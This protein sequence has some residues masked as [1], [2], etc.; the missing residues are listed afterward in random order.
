M[1]MQLHFLCGLVLFSGLS[2][3]GGKPDVTVSNEDKNKKLVFSN[4]VFSYLDDPFFRRE[5]L[6][7]SLTNPLNQYSQL[8]LKK[9]NEEN[10]GSLEVFNPRIRKV[11]PSDIGGSVP[12]PDF[13][14]QS[15][16][17][18]EALNE[19]S[20]MELGLLAFTTYPAQLEPSFSSVI[21]EGTKLSE[22]GL[23]QTD[24]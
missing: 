9:Y 16:D 2:C 8:R 22:F 6:E 11:V 17:I 7:A 4:E 15:L 10:W 1:D 24:D 3:F 20:L 23:W 13:T 19:R 14:W 12:Q 5:A 21:K 18:K